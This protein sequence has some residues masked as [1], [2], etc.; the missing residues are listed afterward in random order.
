M[1][2]RPYNR[3]RNHYLHGLHVAPT[4]FRGVRLRLVAILAILVPSEK[5]NWLKGCQKQVAK[6]ECPGKTSF[7]Y[8]NLI[9]L[10]NN[11]RF[12]TCF[13]SRFLGKL[14]SL[15]CGLLAAWRISSWRLKLNISEL[16]Q[17]QHEEKTNPKQHLDPCHNWYSQHVDIH[18]K[19]VRHIQKFSYDLENRLFSWPSTFFNFPLS[20]LN[21]DSRDMPGE[22]FLTQPGQHRFRAMHADLTS[23]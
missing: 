12:K 14:P 13:A 16:I 9:S 15:R 1:Q 6:N 5:P 11:W 8:S 7:I 4:R 23:V 19:Y 10:V 20:L 2:W 22:G 18:I 17:N 21:G 3:H